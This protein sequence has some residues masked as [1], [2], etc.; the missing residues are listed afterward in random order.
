MADF[1]GFDRSCGKFAQQRKQT[2]QGLSI[3]STLSS[4]TPHVSFHSQQKC[5]EK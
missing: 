1:F 2:S 4:H 3:F 5:Y